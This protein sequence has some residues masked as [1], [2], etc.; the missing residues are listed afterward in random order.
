MKKLFL[1]LLVIVVSLNSFG[2]GNSQPDNVVTTKI[3]T[4]NVFVGTLVEGFLK[5]TKGFMI[6]RILVY[7]TSL[8]E[9]GSTAFYDENWKV[10]KDVFD[11]RQRMTK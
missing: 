8:L 2:Q 6:R 7:K 10:I 1:S 11:Y 5:Y 4:A 3:D 9:V